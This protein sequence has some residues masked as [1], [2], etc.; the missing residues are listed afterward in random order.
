MQ[1]LNANYRQFIDEFVI[2]IYSINKS[3]TEIILASDFNINLLKV[4]E[5]ELFSDFLDIL[6]EHRL[7]KNY[8]SN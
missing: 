5:K 7:K 4:N 6:S 8:A 2:L 1:D 3:N